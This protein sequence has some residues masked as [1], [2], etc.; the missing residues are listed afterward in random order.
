MQFLLGLAVAFWLGTGRYF[1]KQEQGSRQSGT[2]E[3]SSVEDIKPRGSRS[4]LAWTGRRGFSRSS[5]SF[6]GRAP[7]F[8]RNFPRPQRTYCS[9]YW[10]P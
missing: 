9:G 4:G 7:L 6:K 1:F 5:V 10:S 3:E 2:T 8:V